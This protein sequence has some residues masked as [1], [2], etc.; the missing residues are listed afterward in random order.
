MTQMLLFG[1]C[2]TSWVDAIAEEMIGNVRAAG[3]FEELRRKRLLIELHDG[4]AAAPE[5]RQQRI[6]QESRLLSWGEQRV[7]FC[8]PATRRRNAAADE[9][10]LQL[11]N[12]GSVEAGW[13]Q[14]KILDEPPWG[15]DVSFTVEHH[16]RQFLKAF[17]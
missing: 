4:T 12:S 11:R 1:I 5:W 13:N 10:D 14:R 7:V 17:T 3:L 2:L 9:S 6:T 16:A 8:F 15:F